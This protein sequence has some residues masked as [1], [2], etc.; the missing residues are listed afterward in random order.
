MVWLQRWRGR[1]PIKALAGS[2]PLTT[3]VTRRAASCVTL[4]QDRGR[5]GGKHIGLHWREL[6][7]RGLSKWGH[8]L[9]IFLEISDI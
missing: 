4:C 5:H 2:G 8:R 1:Y 7:I 6:A 9:T 3:F